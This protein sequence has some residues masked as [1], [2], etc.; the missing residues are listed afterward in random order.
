MTHEAFWQWFVTYQNRSSGGSVYS[1]MVESIT[2]TLQ[3][4]DRRLGIEISEPNSGGVRD[5]IITANQNK[6][7]FPLVEALVEAAPQIKG[8]RF[9]ALKPE[10]GFAFRF[11]QDGHDLSPT[12]WSFMV[13]RDESGR[14]GIRL[15]IPGES[16]ELPDDILRTIVTTG[17][18]EIR[19]ASIVEL[20]YTQTADERSVNTWVPIQKLA[21]FIDWQSPKI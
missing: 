7:L 9:I 12:D 11:L 15:Y 3:S 8:W 21:R 19:S 2:T 6:S 13:L 5:M 18:G 16:V 14:L 1:D 10:R 20:T 4:V 17:I